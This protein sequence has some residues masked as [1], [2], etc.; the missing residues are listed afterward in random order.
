MGMEEQPTAPD[1]DLMRQNS[2]ERPRGASVTT[3]GWLASAPEPLG[4][5]APLVFCFARI[6]QGSLPRSSVTPMLAAQHVSHDSALPTLHR[7]LNS[8]HSR[9]TVAVGDI[10]IDREPQQLRR[11]PKPMSPI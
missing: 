4:G 8:P 2:A 5:Q 10:V 3:T 7:R 11:H 1:D 9:S 6:P